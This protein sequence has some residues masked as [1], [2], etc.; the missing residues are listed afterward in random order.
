MSRRP[1][2]V[3]AAVVLAGLLLL[4]PRTRGVL[5]GWLGGEPFHALRPLSAWVAQLDDPDDDARNEAAMA[6]IGLGPRAAPAVPAIAAHFRT[7]DGWL[8]QNLGDA[9]AVI[10]APAVPAL[11]ELSA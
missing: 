6:L 8:R 7:A 4:L 11:L 1:H 5:D 3:L 2:P 9:L 10:G